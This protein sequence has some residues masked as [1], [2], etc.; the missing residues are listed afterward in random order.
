MLNNS[1]FCFIFIY[2][3]TIKWYVMLYNTILYWRTIC[4]VLITNS[5]RLSILCQT[6]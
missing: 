4:I 1:I 3:L 6:A 5:A 2:Q